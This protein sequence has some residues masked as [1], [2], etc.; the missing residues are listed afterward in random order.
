MYDTFLKFV[1][2]PNFD[3]NCQI[4]ITVYIDEIAVSKDDAVTSL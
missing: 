4:L 1:S 3:V 2:F